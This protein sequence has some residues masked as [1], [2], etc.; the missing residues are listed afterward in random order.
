VAA[1]FVA[2]TSLTF[3][4][5]RLK[6]ALRPWAAYLA[7]SGVTANQ[8]TVTSLIASV[9]VGA[10]LCVF[11]AKRGLFA[12]LPVWLAVRT[13]CATIDG[14]L[15]IEFRQKSRLGGILNEAGD[16]ISEI[17]LF[18]PLMFVPPFS[19]T[20]IGLLIAL[21]VAS[22]LAGIAPTMAGGERRLEG[23]LG[24]I[25]RSIILS[26]ITIAI[27]VSGWLPENVS[28]LVPALSVGAIVTIG[29][30]VCRYSCMRGG[31]TNANWTEVSAAAAGV[32]DNSSAS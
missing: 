4:K 28:I 1:A 22:E 18:M 16:I 25:D 13:A 29:N 8:V 10:L 2:A 24:K 20:T 5:P 30:R 9:V 31:R 23:P 12:I 14:T 6:T 21:V 11:A 7:R 15:A 26:A 19:A 27:A 3:L 32:R 17:A